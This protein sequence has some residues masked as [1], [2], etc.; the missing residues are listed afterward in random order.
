MIDDLDKT[1]ETLLKRELPPSLVSQVTIS[2][3]APDGQLVDEVSG[4]PVGGNVLPH[5][6]LAPAV[7]SILGRFD[8]LQVSYVAGRRVVSL[9]AHSFPGAPA[10]DLDRSPV[11]LMSGANFPIARTDMM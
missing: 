7:V 5:R 9:E 3:A 2:F 1:I 8:A 4:R 11:I 6:A 10:L